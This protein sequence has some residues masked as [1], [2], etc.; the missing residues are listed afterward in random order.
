MNRHC[1]GVLL[2]GEG[3]YRR[4]EIRYR[5][6]IEMSKIK[7]KVNRHF[8]RRRGDVSEDVMMKI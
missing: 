8:K 7:S 5:E 6:Y 2:Q 4:G 1:K 3:F